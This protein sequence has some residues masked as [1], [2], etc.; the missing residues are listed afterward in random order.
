MSGPGHAGEII[1]ALGHL[2]DDEMVVHRFTDSVDTEPY[3]PI[4]ATEHFYPA[5]ARHRPIQDEPDLPASDLLWQVATMARLQGKTE[6]AE[7]LNR[8]II[9]N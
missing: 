5:T 3:V 2:E 1:A 9:M 8:R 7:L 4:Y 6:T